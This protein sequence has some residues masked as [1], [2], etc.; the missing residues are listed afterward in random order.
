MEYAVVKAS[1]FEYLKKVLHEAVFWSRGENKPTLEEGLSYD[2]TKH[3]LLDFGKRHGDLGIIAKDHDKS[4]GGVFIRLW[5]D[6]E[7]IR[8]YMDSRIPVLVIAVDSK[9]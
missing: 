7:N 3:V 4:V 5:N 8:G 2:Y 1:D 9:V 6:D